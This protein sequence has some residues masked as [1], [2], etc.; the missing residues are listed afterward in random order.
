MS[1]TIFEYRER[2]QVGKRMITKNA[3]AEGMELV[4]A[5]CDRMVEE[6]L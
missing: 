3:L 5:A 2:I 6:G 4:K 1:P